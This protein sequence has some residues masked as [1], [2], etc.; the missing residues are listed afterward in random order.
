[1]TSDTVTL[2]FVAVIVASFLTAAPA[3]IVWLRLRRLTHFRYFTWLALASACAFVATAIAYTLVLI[4]RDN[5]TDIWVAVGFF[6]P[7][8]VVTFVAWTALSLYT[9]NFINGVPHIQEVTTADPVPVV[10]V[11][12]HFNW[13]TFLLKWKVFLTGRKFIM[14]LMSNVG[15]YFAWHSGTLPP[16]HAMIAFLLSVA[17]LVGAVSQEDS[18]AIANTYNLASGADSK[19]GEQHA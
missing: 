17:V 6:V 15:V 4:G 7:S 18:A 2:L 14:W 13:N 5:I 12:G 10:L 9:T 16:E 11:Q 1:M 19:Q 8:I 3:V